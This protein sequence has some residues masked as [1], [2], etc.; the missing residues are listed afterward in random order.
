MQLG[1]VLLALAGLAWWL[2]QR[3]EGQAVGAR[4]RSIRLT[5]EHAVFVVEVEG[6]RW[7]VGTG[8]GGPPALLDTL[9]PP[10]AEDTE[11]GVPRVVATGATPAPV[12]PR[13]T[14]RG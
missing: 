1:L 8:P 10:Q 12:A 5:A 3:V 9:P 13:W 2:R 4:G 14:E 7:L 11:P 6:K